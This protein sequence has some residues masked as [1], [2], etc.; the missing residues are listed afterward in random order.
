MLVQDLWPDLATR[1]LVMRAYLGAAERDCYDRQPPRGRRGWLLG[2]LAVKDAVRHVL[3]AGGQ[4]A[5]WPAEIAVGNDERGKP[6]VT[7]M[8]GR[9]LPCLEVSVAHCAEAAVAF[10]GSAAACPVGID[11]E[12]VR[13]RPAETVEFALSLEEREL[14]TNCIAGGDDPELWFARFWTAKE[15]V[16]KARGTGFQGR[17]RDF[18]VVSAKEREIRLAV[19]DDTSGT[20]LLYR[21]DVSCMTNRPGLPTRS[22][23]VALAAEGPTAEDIE[24]RHDRERTT[25]A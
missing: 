4:G 25:T 10:A 14:L 23:V 16:A 19:T 15:A 5:V 24:R 13:A 7:G 20:N 22:Y 2:R 9:V 11:I 6:Y 21:V 1:D 8:H 12:E 17:P 18:A 3:W